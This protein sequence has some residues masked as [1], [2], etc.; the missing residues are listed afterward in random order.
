MTV[1]LKTYDP[2]HVQLQF[3]HMAARNLNRAVPGSICRSVNPD[4]KTVLTHADGTPWE[5]N[6][7]AVALRAE[8][9]P[10][11]IREDD[12]GTKKEAEL[13]ALDRKTVTA[14]MNYPV[15]TYADL[16]E[17]PYLGT[18]E[19]PV[20]SWMHVDMSRLSGELAKPSVGRR[21]DGAPLFY[22]GKVNTVFGDSEGGK[23]WICLLA[24]AQE[25][26]AGRAVVYLDYEDD[27][28]SILSRL[29]ILGVPRATLED[30]ERF[31]YFKLHDGMTDEAFEQYATPYSS[32][33][34]SRA[35]FWTASLVVI[36]AMTEALAADGLSSNSDVDVAGWF[37]RFAR[38]IAAEGPAVVL[39]DHMNLGD[40]TRVTGSQHKK[41][42]VD[43]LSVR[44][45]KGKAFAPGISGH[46][47][48][49]VS[50]DRNGGVRA[51]SPDDYIGRF[52]VP[53][54][55]GADG[56]MRG[57]HIAPPAPPVTE[58][59]KAAAVDFLL[60][61]SV[62]ALTEAGTAV[63]VRSVTEQFRG[64]GYTASDAT[65]R[66]F[67]KAWKDNTHA[68]TNSVS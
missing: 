11:T 15:E 52:V 6:A 4:G 24:C 49:Y 17:V 59:D 45:K 67:V 56:G 60:R 25:L 14:F 55:I 57:A 39:I 61:E 3:L 54:V 5:V 2:E 28:D 8:C 9:R 42:A 26:K 46:S 51:V 38:R 65:I 31:L 47:D 23:S 1:D 34:G 53:E 40:K 12:T 41:S 30:A 10:V 18:E 48:L 29:I 21:E 64:A 44:V 35:G 62:K 32:E 68:T 36:D 16:P 7:L 19:A 27:A 43:G 63:S 22:A 13:P 66:E 58:E 33:A 37:S 50:K 20:T